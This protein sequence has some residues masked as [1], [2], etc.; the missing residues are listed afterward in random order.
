MKKLL[1]IVLSVL[2][3]VTVISSMPLAFA[4]YP[5]SAPEMV[6]QTECGFSVEQGIAV[7]PQI[8][9]ERCREG[10]PQN[11]DSTFTHEIRLSASVR[12]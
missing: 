2:M 1:S 5:N 8:R 12:A 9:S 10:G 6:R 7:G 3:L 4:L 11:L